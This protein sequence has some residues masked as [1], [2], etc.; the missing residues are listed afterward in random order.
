MKICPNGHQ[1]EYSAYAIDEVVGYEEDER[2]YQS[3]KAI[4]ICPICERPLYEKEKRRI[5]LLQ[6][7]QKKW[8]SPR[9]LALC[10]VCEEPV[11]HAYYE[12]GILHAE[13]GFAICSEGNIA[14]H[15][16]PKR[17]CWGKK[18]GHTNF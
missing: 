12:A 14:Y 6:E 13:E 8:K 1:I 9:S 17:D 4:P 3:F 7:A 5:A 10:G 11:E 16:E 2:A 18:T 15:F